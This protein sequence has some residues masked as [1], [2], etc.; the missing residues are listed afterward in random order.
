MEVNRK[1]L[2]VV[3]NG[4]ECLVDLKWY[5]GANRYNNG[6]T[7]FG[8]KYILRLALSRSKA[9]SVRFESRKDAEIK[10]M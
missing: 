3:I 2:S 4:E 9:R 1:D 5:R 7:H 8:N 6:C 10:P